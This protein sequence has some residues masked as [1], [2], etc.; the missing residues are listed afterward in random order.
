MYQSRF[1]QPTRENG[2]LVPLLIDRSHEHTPIRNY[3]AVVVVDYVSVLNSLKDL[4][5]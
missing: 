3:T 2:E 5:L 1:A 4:V